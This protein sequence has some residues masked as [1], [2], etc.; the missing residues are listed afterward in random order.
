M[1]GGM[2]MYLSAGLR[3]VVTEAPCEEFLN[4]QL[5][6]VIWPPT[7]RSS[8]QSCS[9]LKIQQQSRLSKIDVDVDSFL[10]R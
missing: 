6:E 9:K 1:K 5:A 8:I 7:V 10:L 3:V 2:N 4:G